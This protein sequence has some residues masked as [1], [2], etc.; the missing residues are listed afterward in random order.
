MIQVLDYTYMYVYLYIYIYIYLYIYTH[1]S[2]VR[3][4]LLNITVCDALRQQS[5]MK[6]FNNKGTSENFSVDYTS[7]W[8][9]SHIITVCIWD[10]SSLMHVKY[11]IENDKPAQIDTPQ[12][13]S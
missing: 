2:V 11:S 5:Q 6:S 13:H 12:S 1:I 3:T 9:V 7:Y 10:R 4:S 8:V